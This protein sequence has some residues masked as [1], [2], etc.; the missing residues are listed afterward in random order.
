MTSAPQARDHLQI[1]QAKRLKTMKMGNHLKTLHQ[2]LVL[3]LTASICT[4]MKDGQPLSDAALLR[5][6]KESDKTCRKEIRDTC[7]SISSSSSENLSIDKDPLVDPNDDDYSETGTGSK[8]GN[9]DNDIDRLE[10]VIADIKKRGAPK[11][12]KRDEA[13]ELMDFPLVDPKSVWEIPPDKLASTIAKLKKDSA[14]KDHDGRTPTAA[15]EP[16]GANA[17]YRRRPSSRARPQESFAQK[18]KRKTEEYEA[19]RNRRSAEYLLGK[20]IERLRRT[21][22]IDYVLQEL[23]DEINPPSGLSHLDA[24]GVDSFLESL[25]SQL[26]AFKEAL[27]GP[28][29]RSRKPPQKPRK[30]HTDDM[31][32]IQDMKAEAERINEDIANVGK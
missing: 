16:V 19:A 6:M 17:S 1:N 18:M 32:V 26:N 4:G 10:R 23:E 31:A 2:V 30:S 29:S 9:S 21:H 25:D 28:A 14:R 15:K 8:S 20:K 13:T 5:E 11:D 27:E 3:A 22:P 7:G 24:D 12:S